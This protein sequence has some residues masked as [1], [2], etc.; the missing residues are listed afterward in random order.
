MTLLA[1]QVSWDH[2][3]MKIMQTRKRKA[4]EGS[5]R[6]CFKCHFEGGK[7]EYVSTHAYSLTFPKDTL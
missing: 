3:Y 5:S 4:R 6:K 7:D 1:L 2:I